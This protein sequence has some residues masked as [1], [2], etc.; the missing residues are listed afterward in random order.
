VKRRL[1][2]LKAVWWTQNN[3]PL[4]VNRTYPAQWEGMSITP[5]FHKIKMMIM[6]SHN[7][8]LRSNQRQRSPLKKSKPWKA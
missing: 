4:K 8:I 5:L 3:H 7:K 2:W 1:M 6:L